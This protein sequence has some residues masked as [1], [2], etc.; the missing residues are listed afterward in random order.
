MGLTKGWRKDANAAA[1][2]EAMAISTGDGSRDAYVLGVGVSDTGRISTGTRAGATLEFPTTY[3]FGEAIELRYRSTYTAS[4]FQGIYLQTR[5]D[6]ANTSTVRGMEIEARQGAAVAIGNL[7]GLT[8]TANVASTT[9][10]TVTTVIGLD[11]QTTFNSSAYTGTVTSLY[12]LRVKMAIEDGATVTTGY[13]I[14]VETEA[15]TGAP[16]GTARLDAVLGVA[17]SPANGVGYW[18]YGIDTSGTEFTNG[19]GNEVVLWKFIGANGTTYYMVHDTDA[20]TA[21]GVVT[22]DP[23]T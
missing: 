15:V 5:S 2:V 1:G 9:T 23:T 13:S 11:A 17:T 18:R 7:I 14:Y 3:S 10:G 12:G 6:V 22:S 16:T 21:I 19:S 20:A 4:Q 8:S